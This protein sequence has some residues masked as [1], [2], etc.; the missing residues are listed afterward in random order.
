MIHFIKLNIISY[1]IKIVKF[2]KN[3]TDL[4]ISLSRR[5]I[6]K[7]LIELKNGI[8]FIHPEYTTIL[9]K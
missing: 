6:N 2:L 1:L 4:N 8:K 7:F 5:E 9:T 3:I